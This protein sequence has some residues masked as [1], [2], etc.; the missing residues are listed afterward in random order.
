MITKICT[1]FKIKHY[2]SI[3]YRPKM[4]GT[5]EVANKNMKKIITKATEIY[6]NWHEKLPFA[7]HAY[8]TRIRTSTGATPYSLVYRI[9]A[10]LPIE[11]EIP[12]LRVLR[13]VDRKS[14]V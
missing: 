10:V 5:M 6:K 4:N 12:L 11:V 2:N 9:E 13:E 14:V 1:Q 3:P 7:L 8:Q